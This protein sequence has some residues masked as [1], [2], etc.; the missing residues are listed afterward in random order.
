[1]VRNQYTKLTSEQKLEI[2]EYWMK[3]HYSYSDI[4]KYYSIK[5]KQKVNVTTVADIIQH[6]KNK[7]SIRGMKSV[8]NHTTI[9]SSILNEVV[10]SVN[11]IGY[12]LSNKCLHAICIGELMNY[13]EKSSQ[14]RMDEIESVMLNN[15]LQF[16][17]HFN[18][19]NGDSLSTIQNMFHTTSPSSI[20]FL[21]SFY[22]L[23]RSIPF[24]SC[25]FSMDNSSMQFREKMEVLSTFSADGSFR[26]PLF[27]Y[28]HRFYTDIPSWAIINRKKSR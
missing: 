21:D 5:W 28:G 16:I 26:C 22:L 9:L 6:W 4:C 11:E 3:F 7:K 15:E 24:K 10:N 13:D 23:F 19:G 18:M 20:L 8:T 12:T 17:N 25:C 27:I 1:M 14:I 2:I